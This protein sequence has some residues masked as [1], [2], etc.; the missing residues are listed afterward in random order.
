MENRACAGAKGLCL[1]FLF[2]DIDPGDVLLLFISSL[3]FF[4]QGERGLDGFPGKHGD[5]G[6]QV[7][8]HWLRG[9][10]G[11]GAC[12]EL[13]EPGGCG[14][15]PTRLGVPGGLA[16]SP[17]LTATRGLLHARVEG[18]QRT[19]HVKSILTSAVRHVIINVTAMGDAHVFRVLYSVQSCPRES[20]VTNSPN[21][22]Q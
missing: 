13:V 17:Q 16:T 20:K 5:T 15:C 22:H 7:G 8:R 11:T 2:Y 9:P 3:S 10:A 19:H 1:P 6:E 14:L 21:A 18:F 12:A 4:C